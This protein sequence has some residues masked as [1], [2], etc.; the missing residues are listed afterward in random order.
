MAYYKN[1]TE[2]LKSI[3]RRAVTP[4]SQNLFTDQDLLDFATE[5]IESY[6][7]QTITKQ[8]EN[9][10]LVSQDIAIVP[11]Q[12]RYAIPY[13]ATGNKLKDLAFIPQ[14]NPT[15]ICEMSEIDLGEVPD[16][17]Y[18]GNTDQPYSYFTASN[19]IC[20]VPETNNYVGTLRF[21]FYLRT[22]SL[23]PMEEVGVI[24]AIDF[25]LGIITVD[26]VP[27]NFQV[28]DLYD[29][30]ME[31]SPHKIISY[32]SAVSSVDVGT[33]QITFGPG[34]LPTSLRVGD[35]VCRA[36]ETA[37]P[38]VPSDL[39]NLVAHRAAAR[40][41]EAI[42]DTEALQ[43]AELK[44]QQLGQ[45]AADTVDNRVETSAKKIVNRNGLMRTGISSNRRR[46]SR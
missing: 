6:I 12:S 19:E 31:R 27:E 25:D 22:N 9:Y 42:G 21:S 41:L 35:H 24:T 4:E 23:V 29:L 36:T 3:K 2:L 37:I 10:F 8:Q 38:N 16:Y 5:E 28:T 1:S 40:I 33:G 17:N 44:S 26:K 32:D 43:I 34:N 13:R 39:H 7:V 20:L 15:E 18:S 46:W 45:N 30:V 11:G 14:N